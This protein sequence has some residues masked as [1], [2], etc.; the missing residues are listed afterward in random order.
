MRHLTT[1]DPYDTQFLPITV[2]P[3][4][5]SIPIALFIL[6]LLFID[7][8][9]DHKTLSPNPT[10][11]S[12]PQQPSQRKLPKN[13]T[14]SKG[15]HSRNNSI[16]SA[17]SLKVTPQPHQPPPPLA[18][19]FIPHTPCTRDMSYPSSPTS[20]VAETLVE[21]PKIRQPFDALL[22]LDF[23]ATCL[24]GSGF[25]FPNEIIVRISSFQPIVPLLRIHVRTGI[26]CGSSSMG[27]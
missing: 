16:S 27:R 24:P 21:D 23:E 19:S 26:P 8:P 14:R 10:T 20:S 25:D 18:L 7:R 2:L 5:I 1:P 12:K 22:V 13:R 17:A 9:M 3:V 6:H 15:K 4:V 11:S